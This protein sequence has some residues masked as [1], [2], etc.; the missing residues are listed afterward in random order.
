MIKKAVI[1]EVLKSYAMQ[2]WV[3]WI[4]DILHIGIAY[5]ISNLSTEHDDLT[6]IFIYL[7]SYNISTKNYEIA[8]EQTL[9]QLQPISQNSILIERILNALLVIKS[10]RVKSF[11]LKIYFDKKYIS[12][13]G[14]DDFIVCKI[15]NVLT[16]LVLSDDEKQR[17]NESVSGIGGIF[18]KFK[19]NS[20]FHINYLRFLRVQY[21]EKAYFEGVT[22]LIIESTIPSI[23]FTIIN[24]LYELYNSHKVT[25]YQRLFYWIVS[26]FNIIN[27]SPNCRKVIMQI[28]KFISH[29]N[30]KAD[31]DNINSK[32]SLYG[33]NA[34]I[35]L[36]FLIY[37]IEKDPEILE[38]FIDFALK[39]ECYGVINYIFK[40]N[41]KSFSSEFTL[42]KNILSNA[43]NLEY[44]IKNKETFDMIYKYI[45][46]Y[47]LNNEIDIDIVSSI[48]ENHK[49]KIRKFKENG[50]FSKRSQ[51]QPA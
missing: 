29:D 33:K 47:G 45:N 43:K 7:Q 14:T 38:K 17:I 26:D 30:R 10:S 18:I 48:D 40:S 6:E 42:Y 36:N 24:S 13:K 44:E 34:L 20:S 23:P 9:N 41:L 8:I 19:N 16:R 1:L 46:N 39:S 25:F 22:F 28:V 15:L 32:Q 21:D 5:P 4:D 2:D 12:A 50:G 27:K 31:L 49:V 3:D 51:L 35:L 37:K 11:L